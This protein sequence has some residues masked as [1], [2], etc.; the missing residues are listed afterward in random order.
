MFQVSHPPTTSTTRIVL[1]LAAA[2][3]LAIGPVASATASPAPETTHV[4]QAGWQQIVTELAAE[5]RGTS[6][7]AAR[8]M[9]HSELTIVLHSHR[10]W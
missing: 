1:A 6:S 10:D 9:L 4:S 8:R 7:L 2:A 3:A 5:A